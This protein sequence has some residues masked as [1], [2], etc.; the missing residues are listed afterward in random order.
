MG[1][2]MEEGKEIELGSVRAG[3]DFNW[4]LSTLHSVLGFSGG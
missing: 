4:T 3:I 1:L 2:Q